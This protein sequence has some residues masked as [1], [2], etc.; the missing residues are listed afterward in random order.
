MIRGGF[1]NVVLVSFDWTPCWPPRVQA[2]GPPAQSNQLAEEQE[3]SLGVSSLQRDHHPLSAT[4]PKRGYHLRLQSQ[5]IHCRVSNQ[6]SGR[7]T[8]INCGT[9]LTFLPPPRHQLVRPFSVSRSTFLHGDPVSRT[10]PGELRGWRLA[11]HALGGQFKLFRFTWVP[12]PRQ[13]SL[14][15]S[16]CVR[17]P[18]WI[19]DTSSNNTLFQMPEDQTQRQTNRAG[20]RWLWQSSFSADNKVPMVLP[21]K[22]LEWFGWLGRSTTTHTTRCRTGSKS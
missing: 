14:T 13:H 2:E 12:S 7:V 18:L 4:Q 19:Q 1:L 10:E 22:T 8:M 20:H 16:T 17:L 9:R 15:L 3:H 21:K 5:G 6:W 11:Q